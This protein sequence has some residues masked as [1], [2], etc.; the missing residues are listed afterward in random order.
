VG[1]VIWAA[2]GPVGAGEGAGA[3]VGVGGGGDSGAAT[4]PPPPPHAFKA[5]EATVAVA[6]ARNSCASVRRRAACTAGEPA[7]IDESI[8]SSP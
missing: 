4:L 2:I 8:L 5:T 3:G 7:L 1:T 6:T